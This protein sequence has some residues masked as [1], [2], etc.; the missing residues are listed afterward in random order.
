MELGDKIG[1]L[2]YLGKVSKIMSGKPRTYLKFLCGCGKNVEIRKGS[3]EKS[4]FPSCGCEKINNKIK[5]LLSKEDRLHNGVNFIN[6]K[7]GELIVKELISPL[8]I[9]K[10][11]CQCSCGDILNVR[12]DHLKN[13]E[14]KSCGC[15][16]KE[17]A[18]EAGKKEYGQAA[19]NDTYNSYKQ[20]AKS[21]G[22]S[23]NLT[24]EE[25]KN[26]S[27]KN[28]NY[29]GVV[30]SQIKKVKGDNGDFIYNGIDRIDSSKGYIEGNC[31]TCC[32]TCNYMKRTHSIEDF[33]NH[34]I[35]LY[36]NFAK[37][38]ANGSGV[39]TWS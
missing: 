3:I 4:N 28:C 31:I 15:K 21:R 17:F 19:F 38:F 30:P 34:I 12:F 10:Y 26:L 22:I 35:K 1:K 20:G 33:A 14:T 23:F 37:N 2:T 29:C 32:G 6:E 25:F 18:R 36:H 7:F 13:N 27:S 39:L 5:T 11:K 16:R 24:K 9:I 8:G